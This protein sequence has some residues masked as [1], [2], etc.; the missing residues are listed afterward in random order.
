MTLITTHPTPLIHDV[1]SH[2]L[3]HVDKDARGINMNPLDAISKHPADSILPKDINDARGS[4]I[5]EK[6][7][8]SQKPVKQVVFKDR[9]FE[10][11]ENGKVV[12]QVPGQSTHIPS[13]KDKTLIK[14]GINDKALK[15]VHPDSQKAAAAYAKVSKTQSK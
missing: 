8:A 10:V 5:T 3:R 6:A 9:G 4:N 2:S 15:P 12:K 14:I 7:K 13:E 11:M 1:K